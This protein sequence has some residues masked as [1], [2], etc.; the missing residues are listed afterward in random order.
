MGKAKPHPR[1]VTKRPFDVPEAL[2]KLRAVT[3]SFPKA[4]LFE[5]AAEGHDSVF[6]QLVACVISIRTYDEVMLPAARR[7][8]VAAPTPADL[9]AL[10]EAEIDALIHP[11]TFHGAKAKTIRT[12]ARQTV[13]EHG[14]T[15]PGE[16]EVLMEFSGVGPKCANLAVGIACGLPLIGVDIHVH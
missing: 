9:A 16:P 5:L 15:L 3:A 11:S 14:G 7:L 13:A 10:S 8:F 4:A 1:Q 2:E 12:I 6:E